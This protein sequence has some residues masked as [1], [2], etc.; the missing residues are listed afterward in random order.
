M[1]KLE[2]FR[3]EIDLFL[4]QVL[5]AESRGHVFVSLA[6]D[7]LTKFEQDWRKAAGDRI[8]FERFADGREVTSLAGISGPKVIAERVVTLGLAV[9]RALEL[10][11]LFTKV[12][13]GDYKAQTFVLAGGSRISAGEADQISSDAEVEIVNVTPFSRKAEARGFNDADSSGFKNGLFES[14][15]A[16]LKQEALVPVKFSFSGQ[17]GARLP[18]II[19]GGRG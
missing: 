12:V 9:N 15:A 10:F 17:G 1:A 18:S 11:D 16:I 19:I 13:T 4:N 8:T 6:E 14:I 2:A 7:R 5:S 3:T